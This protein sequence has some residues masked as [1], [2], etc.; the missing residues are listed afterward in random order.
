[1]GGL[2]CAEIWDAGSEVGM[3]GLVGVGAALINVDAQMN[4]WRSGLEPVMMPVVFSRARA[5]CR[6]SRRRRWWGGDG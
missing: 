4:R 5:R 1:M 6:W 2:I 3:A